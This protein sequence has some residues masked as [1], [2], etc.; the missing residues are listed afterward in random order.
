MGTLLHHYESVPD[1][2]LEADPTQ[3]AELLGGPS[4]IHLPGRRKQ[5]LF[6]SVL[7]HGNETTGWLALQA[8]LKRHCERELPRALSFFYG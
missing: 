5:P 7:L 4:L 3:L 2:L 8:L 1:G 6:I